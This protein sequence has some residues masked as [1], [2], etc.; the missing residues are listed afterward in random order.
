MT[1]TECEHTKDVAN[2]RIHV[3]QAINCIKTYRI[4]KCFAKLL[5]HHADDIVRTCGALCN[6]KA[7]LMYI[8][9]RIKG[10]SLRGFFKE[11]VIFITTYF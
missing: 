3:E 4:F 10:K 9:P 8:L 5:L 7:P 2:I 1:T 6:P 11:T